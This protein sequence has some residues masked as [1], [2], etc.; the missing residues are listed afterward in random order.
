MAQIRMF[1]A[2]P[3]V[4]GKLRTLDGLHVVAITMLKMVEASFSMGSL[5]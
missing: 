1:S 4:T 2:G 5:H 3:I